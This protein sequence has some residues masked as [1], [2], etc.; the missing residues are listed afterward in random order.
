MPFQLPMNTVSPSTGTQLS[1]VQQ[2][3]PAIANTLVANLTLVAGALAVLFLIYGG[4]RYILAG[5]SADRAKEA[6]AGIIHVVI[7]IIV[8]V[9]AYFIVRLAVSVGNTVTSS[10]P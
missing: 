9:S 2:V 8:I 4:I 1:D 10:V 6:R 3:I 5:G 7:G